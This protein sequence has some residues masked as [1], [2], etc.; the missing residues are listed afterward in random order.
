MSL[1]TIIGLI[2]FLLL[3]SQSACATDRTYQGKV[4]DADTLKPIKG[5]VVVAI[6]RKTRAGIAGSDTRFKDAKETLTDKKGEWAIVGPEGYEA[7]IIPG[8]IQL[9]GVFVTTS[10]EI[11][12]YKPGYR[13]GIRGGF[14]AYPYID[15][16]HNLEGIVLSRPGE[17]LEEIKEYSKKYSVGTLRFIP[18]KDPEKKLRDLDFSF[19]YPENVKTVGWKRGMSASYLV[20]G[21]KKA[22]TRE[23]RLD[24]MSFTAPGKLP[25][26]HKM[27]WEE[28]GRLLGQSRTR[29]TSEIIPSPRSPAT[30]SAKPVD[31]SKIPS[32]PQN[33]NKDTPGI[34]PR[35][36]KPTSDQ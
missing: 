13:R 5:A 33:I 18:V 32:P 19:Q 14:S 23:E 31:A 29:G 20:I 3:V 27:Q 17:T 30:S 28:R 25:L 6:W 11:I 1:R 15:R 26:T 2:L 7:K 9:I 36:K 4:I 12:Y 21:L 10:P 8:L 16:E 35:L 22:K 24:A 34:S